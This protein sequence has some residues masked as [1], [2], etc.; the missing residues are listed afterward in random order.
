MSYGMYNDCILTHSNSVIV[1]P[2]I[3]QVNS[4]EYKLNKNQFHYGVNLTG[5]T[6]YAPCNSVVVFAGYVDSFYGVIIQYD[7]N[8]YLRFTH[9]SQIGVISGDLIV[10]DTLIG[11]CTDYFHFEYLSTTWCNTESIAIGGVV[12]YKHNPNSI[13]NREFIFDNSVQLVPNNL[14]KYYQEAY[15]PGYIWR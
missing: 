12:L 11:H 1:L 9:L 2:W 4:I 3:S 7:V 15:P 5:N 14:D 13:L 10:V 6:I 8:T